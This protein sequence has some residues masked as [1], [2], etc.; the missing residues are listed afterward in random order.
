M[1]VIVNIRPGPAWAPGQTVYEQGESV[2]RHL[3]SM[4]NLY[5]DGRL[6]VGGPFASATSGM[7]L[8]DVEN[9]DEAREIMETDPGVVSGVFSY[10]LTVWR[11]YFDVFAGVRTDRIDSVL[12]PQAERA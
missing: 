5:D 2:A 4:R 12:S 6:L 3:V 10:E 11:A 1:R 7:A 9:L 8:L